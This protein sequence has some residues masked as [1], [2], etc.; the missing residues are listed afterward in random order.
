V[1]KL[2]ASLLVPFADLLTEQLR[3]PAFRDR[4]ERTAPLARAVA[5]GVVAYRAEHGLSQG[6]SA[7]SWG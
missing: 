3:D 6:N 1:T 7:K 4:W 2:A 5:I